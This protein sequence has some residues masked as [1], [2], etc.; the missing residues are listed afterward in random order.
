MNFNCNNYSRRDFI[1]LSSAFAVTAVVPKISVASQKSKTNIILI[2]ADDIGFECFGCYGSK[3]YSTPNLDKLAA[4]GIR[5]THCYAQPLCTPSRVKL[6]TGKSN[7]R[8][9]VDFSVLD[10]SQQTFGQMLKTVGYKTCIA[11]KWQLFGAEH[12]PKEVRGT[13]TL[14]ED[15]GF[16]THCLWQVEKLGE[17]Y[18]GPYLRID[19]IHKQFPKE[20]YGPD[21][22]TNHIVDFIE[23]NSFKPFF[24]YYPMILVHNPFPVTPDSKD[25]KCKDKQKNFADMVNYM[26][27]LIGKIIDTVKSQ[28]IQDN[29]LIM[30]VGDNGTNTSIISKL[31]NLTIQGAKSKTTDY[32]TRVPLIAN[33]LDAKGAVVCDDLVDM[34]DFMPTIAEATGMKLPD[35]VKIDGQSFFPQLKG[36]KGNPRD[37]IFMYYN[38]RPVAK[39]NQESSFARDKRWKL[40]S[41]GKLYDIKNDVMEKSPIT[42]DKD[43]QETKT[44]R[45]KLQDI[46]NSMP[47]KPQMIRKK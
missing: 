46:I 18:W 22:C 42:V 27:K 13:G 38:P 16:D 14:P 37:A 45:R 41:D 7:I 10:K 32:G 6:M 29:T 26:D 33:M 9:Y 43:T 47:A 31:G 20:S 40:Y 21:V 4:D 11:G 28:N 34:S 1:R 19:G 30:F 23:K 12:Y 24:V 5:F 3:M 17:R 44:I 2:M 36:Q 35:N 25:P 39:P 8:N 15:A